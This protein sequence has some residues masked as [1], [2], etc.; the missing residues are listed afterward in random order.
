MERM[1]GTKSLASGDLPELLLLACWFFVGPQS[2]LREHRVQPGGS[3]GGG[4][5]PEISAGLTW[6][7]GLSPCQALSCGLT[8]LTPCTQL[9]SALLL[10]D[11][12]GPKIPAF[13]AWLCPGTRT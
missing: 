7:L 11:F 9:H 4:D 5:S 10:A 13:E 8:F 2:G 3:T 12:M 6:E 1:P